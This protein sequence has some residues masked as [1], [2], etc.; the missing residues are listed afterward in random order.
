LLVRGG[1]KLTVSI[2]GARMMNYASDTPASINNKKAIIHFAGCF[3]KNEKLYN[4][5]FGE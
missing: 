5:T 4:K 1:D 3:D 2:W